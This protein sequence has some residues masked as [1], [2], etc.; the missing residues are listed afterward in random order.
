MAGDASN[1][2]VLLARTAE[3][4]LT[5]RVLQQGA[6][7]R[8]GLR[9][10]SG[11]DIGD[12]L[13]Q[14]AHTAVAVLP[15]DMAAVFETVPQQE[16]M[17]LRAGV[18]WPEDVVGSRG[19]VARETAI[20]RIL[21]SAE[22]V[23]LND[24]D[25]ETHGR[26]WGLPGHVEV[27][28]SVGVAIIESGR[29][30]GVLAAHSIS[31][32]AFTDGDATFLQSIANLIGAALSRAHSD[33]AMRVAL[34]R[35]TEAVDRLRSLNEMKNAF[36]QAVSHELRTP[37]ASVLGF[38]LTLQ[39]RK[40]E[41]DESQT[42]MMLDR[43]AVNARKLDR[44]LRDLLDL[45]RLY[46]RTIRPARR[47]TDVDELIRAAVENVELGKRTVHVPSGRH[48]AMVDGPKVERI[49]ENL[50]VNA[51]RHTPEGTSIWVGVEDTA[52][53]LKIVV[54]DSGPGVPDELK[55]AVFDVFR[56]GTAGPAVTTG[57][58]IGL[59][60]VR[61]FAEMHGGRA[62]VE[63]RDEGGARFCVLLPDSEIAGG[64]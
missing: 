29:V 21:D 42:E 34:A 13:E 33:E 12:L 38:A 31:V 35:E 47:P 57:T 24:I 44:L 30:Y 9:A 17:V 18:G 22:P 51:V 55:L 37:L 16:Q 46:R 26:E 1:D 58:G 53:G 48:H 5:D 41:L 62:W 56:T 40:A 43:L 3:E 45:D 8:L 36:L 32:N 60:L 63:D 28:S 27:R 39:E 64:A 10:L 61:R 11:I 59:S 20:R 6:I 7:A 14:A 19:P 52:D 15:A 4:E 54:E 50:I 25:A 49:L 23:V 2:T